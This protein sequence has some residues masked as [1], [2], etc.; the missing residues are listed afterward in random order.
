MPLHRCTDLEHRLE[1]A[2]K[3]NKRAMI[4]AEKSEDARREAV[5]AV[6]RRAAL[7]MQPLPQAACA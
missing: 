4:D 1:L 7:G 3:L 6:S 5:A 2:N